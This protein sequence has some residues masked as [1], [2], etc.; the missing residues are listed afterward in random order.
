M[1][2]EK[3]GTLKYIILAFVPV[4]VRTL[5]YKEKAKVFLKMDESPLVCLLYRMSRVSINGIR[6]GETAGGEKLFDMRR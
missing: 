4:S 2:P 3:Q 5:N 1:K 6:R